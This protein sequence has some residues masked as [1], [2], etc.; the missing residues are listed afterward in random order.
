MPARNT[1]SDCH[2]GT[3]YCFSIWTSRLLECYIRRHSY[4]F[5]HL[6]L[7]TC[8]LHAVS[9]T[10]SVKTVYILLDIYSWSRLHI[11]FNLSVPMKGRKN[12]VLRSPTLLSNT[13]RWYG[14]GSLEFPSGMSMREAIISIILSTSE[15]DI[16]PSCIGGLRRHTLA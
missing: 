15:S 10:S 1:N 5:L 9:T 14:G 6:P 8:T 4:C 13:Q 7:Y 11:S 3:I 2:R 16:C 12:F